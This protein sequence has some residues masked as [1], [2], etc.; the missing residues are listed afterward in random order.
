MTT[1]LRASED[2][3]FVNRSAGEPE[4]HG[5]EPGAPVLRFD[6]RKKARV[7]FPFAQIPFAQ[8]VQDDIREA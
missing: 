8:K 1:P 6:E 4:Q 2:I 3:F 5:A 7:L